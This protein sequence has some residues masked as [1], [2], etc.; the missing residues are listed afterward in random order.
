MSITKVLTSPYRFKERILLYGGA[1]VG[2]SSVT[3]NIARHM[4]ESTFHVIDMD[5]SMTYDRLLQTEYQ[6]V[7]ERGNVKIHTVG[8]D[9]D[10]FTE[11]FA[12]IIS[13]ANPDTDW[14]TVDPATA[15]WDM[16]Q[17]WWSDTVIGN[18]I[19]DHMAQLKRD[20]KDA[21]E[22]SA[23]IADTMQWPAINKQY[24][25]KF[26]GQMHKWHGHM[27]LCCEPNEIRRDEDADVKSTYGFVGYKPKGQKT[28]PHVAA[29]NIFL[30]HPKIDQWRMTSVKDRGRELVE[31]VN[32]TSFADDYLV[33]VAGWEMSMVK[34]A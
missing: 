14:I 8:T 10:L 31:K 3:L 24:Q 29:T 17:G 5:Y 11:T 32:L 30:D 6:D 33:D 2:K 34:D 26:Y 16:V 19:A 13:E 1:G 22:Y 27:I 4:P 12:K 9:W 25:Q 20:S 21:R 7:E 23:A 15:T 18:N 28:L